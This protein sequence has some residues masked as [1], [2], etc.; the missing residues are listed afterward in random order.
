MKTVPGKLVW[1][2]LLV[3]A[4]GTAPSA[5]ALEIDFDPAEAAPGNM[6]FA[7]IHGSISAKH[8]TDVRVQVHRYNGH[9]FF[10]RQNPAVHW[11]AP[12]MYLLFGS[13]RALLIDTGATEEAEYFPIR[14][15]VDRLIEHWEQ[16][17]GVSDIELLVLTSGDAPAQVAGMDQFRGRAATELLELEDGLPKSRSI[18]RSG[19]DSATID[20]GGRRLTVLSTPGVSATGLSVYDP[21]TD[22]LFSGTVLLPGRI[23][24]RDFDSY[25]ASLERLLAFADSQPIK[26]VMGAHIDMS[27]TPGID[28]RLRSNFRPHER[29]LQLPATSLQRCYDVVN[30]INNTRRVEILG[31]FI[32]MNGMGRGERLYGYPGYT[33]EFLEQRFLR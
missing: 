20:L 14:Q 15:T 8:N 24:I 5:A 3:L 10:L 26:W 31:D 18:R 32:V 33:P 7:W 25:K 29:A 16:A 12:F 22:F 6:R 23:V 30:L 19:E 17:N 28:Y 9:S 4:L 21:Y 11:E 27:A 2:S 1:I 13:E